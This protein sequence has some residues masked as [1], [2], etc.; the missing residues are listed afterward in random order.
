M[1]VDKFLLQRAEEWTKLDPNEATSEY[2]ENLL[3]NF[4]SDPE[5]AKELESLFPDDRIGFGTAGLR[6]EM[7]PGPMGTILFF[8]RV[9][10]VFHPENPHF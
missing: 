1:P 10:S 3:N 8:M 4:E 2:V 6:S 7:K 5:K 9:E